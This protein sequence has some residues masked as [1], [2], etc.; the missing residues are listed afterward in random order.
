[1]NQSDPK[2]H[3]KVLTTERT[4]NR[5]TSLSNSQEDNIEMRKLTND[6]RVCKEAGVKFVKDLTTENK[7]ARA[8]LWPQIS[9]AKKAGE[10]TYFRGP[11][12]FINGHCIQVKVLSDGSYIN[13]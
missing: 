11:F 8:V 1:M 9:Q 4:E 10:K 5:A 3:L 2:H 6:S 13:Y 7:L 12:G